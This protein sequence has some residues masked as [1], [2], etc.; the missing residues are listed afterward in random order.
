VL[1]TDADFL[2]PHYRLAARAEQIGKPLFV[3]TVNDPARTG[4]LFERPLVQAIVTNNP[5]QALALRS[6]LR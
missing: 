6:E 1:S 2:V 5:R 4:R 3:W